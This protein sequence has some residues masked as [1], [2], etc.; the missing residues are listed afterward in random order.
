M[1]SNVGNKIIA[2]ATASV[3]GSLNL[4]LVFIIQNP[5]HDYK[6]YII[7]TLVYYTL[8]IAFLIIVSRALVYFV[9]HLNKE[10]SLFVIFLIFTSLILLLRF[11]ICGDL[12]FLIAFAIAQFTAMLSYLLLKKLFI[13]NIIQ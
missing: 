13:R 8:W 5:I 1:R 9:S 7:G 2:G 6:D 4:A 3:F 11:K 10:I 12:D